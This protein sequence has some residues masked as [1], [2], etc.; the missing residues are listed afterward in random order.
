[1]QLPNCRHSSTTS[2]C[3]PDSE[4]TTQNAQHIII[5]NVQCQTVTE[6]YSKKLIML[7][8]SLFAAA[9]AARQLTAIAKARSFNTMHLLLG[10]RLF[11]MRHRIHLLQQKHQQAWTTSTASGMDHIDDIANSY[12]LLWFTSSDISFSFLF[13]RLIFYVLCFW[14]WFFMF[15]VF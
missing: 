2:M 14:G 5:Q 9:A 1:M 3:S 11:N 8:Y 13:F 4:P 12:Y 6:T 10:K 7:K 15:Y